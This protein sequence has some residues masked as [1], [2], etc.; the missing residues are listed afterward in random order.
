VKAQ[1]KKAYRLMELKRNK[2]CPT[3]DVPVDRYCSNCIARLLK[4]GWRKKCTGP[5]TAEIASPAEIPSPARLTRANATKARNIQSRVWISSSAARETDSRSVKQLDDDA[6]LPSYFK[7][8]CNTARGVK[9]A[10]LEGIDDWV[11]TWV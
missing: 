1:D 11:I 4:P 7:T 8:V 3:H 9:T 6:V 10:Q 5:K 2:K